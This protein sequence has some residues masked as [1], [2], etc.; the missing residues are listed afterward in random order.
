[1]RSRSSRIGAV[2]LAV[3]ATMAL[4]LQAATAAGSKFL[5]PGE[6]DAARLL[7][8]PPPDGSD[9]QKSELLELH[10]IQ[11]TR[12]RESFARAKSDA[13]N[14][15]V[16]IFAGAL[17]PS[18]DIA[19][20]PVTAKL[21]ADIDQEEE[22]ATTPAKTF[23][24]RLRPYLADRTLKDCGH[25]PTK[26]GDNS[27]P[28]GHATVAYAMG[29]VLASLVPTR[30]QDILKRSQEFAEERL[31]CGVHYR[32]DIEGG[33]ALGTVLGVKLMQARAFKPEFDAAEAELRAAGLAEAES[34]LK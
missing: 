12:T 23:F 22:V 27:Y 1:M 34:P 26:R 24:H 29:T 18:F 21:F 20:L 17:G 10:H 32:S 30:A 11:D 14:E 3:A 2:V 4:S 7:P 25:D 16:T 31:I 5:E 13:A 28:S 19:K 9:R 6:I 8:P 15:T 33:E